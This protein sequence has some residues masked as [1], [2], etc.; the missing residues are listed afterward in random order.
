MPRPKR[1]SPLRELTPEQTA[2]KLSV[3]GL[4]AFWE[5]SATELIR[6]GVP[7]APPA[8]GKQT[9]RRALKRTPDQLITAELR[10]VLGRC[11]QL[12]QFWGITSADLIAAKAPQE[13]A[14]AASSGLIDPDGARSPLK[15]YKHPIT[16]EVWNGAGAQPDWLKRALTHEGYTVRELLAG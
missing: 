4:I 7:S 11:R 3:Q 6:A 10:Q 13:S 16:Q 15:A 2:A 1:A 5:I 12:A 14:V 9:S 8:P